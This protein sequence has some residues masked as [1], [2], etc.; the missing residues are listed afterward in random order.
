MNDSDYLFALGHQKRSFYSRNQPEVKHYFLK[1]TSLFFSYLAWAPGI[2]LL[3]S[4]IVG[5]WEALQFQ[6][7]KALAPL[8]SC[9]INGNWVIS[10]K[11]WYGQDL[12]LRANFIKSVVLIFGSVALLFCR[13]HAPCSYTAIT[14]SWNF[15]VDFYGQTTPDFPLSF[16]TRKEMLRRKCF[17]MFPLGLTAATLSLITAAVFFCEIFSVEQWSQ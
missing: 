13:I 6:K 16:P 12:I 9:R 7:L 2:S 11:I 3:K 10:H 14:V 17:Y 1:L 15:A 4:N 8:L 5:L